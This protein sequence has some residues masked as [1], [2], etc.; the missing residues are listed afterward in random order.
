MLWK[1]GRCREC[2]PQTTPDVSACRPGG[3][4]HGNVTSGFPL[5]HWTASASGDF[6]VAVL[7]ADFDDAPASLGDARGV[8]FNLYEAHRYLTE[9]A[10]RPVRAAHDLNRSRDRV[11]SM[12]CEKIAL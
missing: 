7:L 4:A 8:G 5:P 9:R 12:T 11:R 6:D 10:L 2:L 1:D 3:R